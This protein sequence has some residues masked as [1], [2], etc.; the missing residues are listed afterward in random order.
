MSK[1]QFSLDAARSFLLMR[2]SSIT[3]SNTA[4]AICKPNAIG[5]SYTMRYAANTYAT[6]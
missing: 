4:I 6:I 1:I 5:D 2:Y 3:S